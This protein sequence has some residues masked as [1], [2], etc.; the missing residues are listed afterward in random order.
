MLWQRNVDFAEENID[1]LWGLTLDEL[2]GNWDETSEFFICSG[3][4][5]ISPWDL[6]N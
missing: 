4:A 1:Q 6:Q 5:F 2:W 3:V